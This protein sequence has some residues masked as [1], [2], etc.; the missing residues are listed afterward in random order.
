MGFNI[1]T[2]SAWFNFSC[3][4][5][6]IMINTYFHNMQPFLKIIQISSAMGLFLSVQRKLFF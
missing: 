4:P 3:L 5:V 2:N 1:I 6:R